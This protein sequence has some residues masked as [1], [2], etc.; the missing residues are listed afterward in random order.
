MMMFFAP[1][2][3]WAMAEM[4]DQPAVLALTNSTGRTHT[5]LDWRPVE[6]W[7]G[8]PPV[9]LAQRGKGGVRRAAL[10]AGPAPYCLGKTIRRLDGRGAGESLESPL[11]AHLGDAAIGPRQDRRG[12][13]PR[14][15]DEEALSNRRVHVPLRCGGAGAFPPSSC[16]GHD[17]RPSPHPARAPERL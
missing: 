3:T 13:E 17:A 16:S 15:V 7:L 4:A 12:H 1:P 6:D 2:I 11:A 9:V 5:H 14:Y 8:R 10:P